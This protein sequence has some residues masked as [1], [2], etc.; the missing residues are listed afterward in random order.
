MQQRRQGVV[1]VL[2]GTSYKTKEEEDRSPRQE[3]LG[4]E[5][6]AFYPMPS[7]VCKGQGRGTGSYRRRNRTPSENKNLGHGTQP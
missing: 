4:R 2:L 1:A 3:A 5:P 7:S 6:F